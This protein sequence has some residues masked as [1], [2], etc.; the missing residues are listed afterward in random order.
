[1]SAGQGIDHG[2]AKSDPS[3]VWCETFVSLQGEGPLAGQRSAFVRFAH[4][5]LTCVWCDTGYSWDRARF[6][7]DQA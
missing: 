7:R 4:C 5:N 1:M 6:C 3:V 2:P